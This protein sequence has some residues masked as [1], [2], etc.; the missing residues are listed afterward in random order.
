[1]QYGVLVMSETIWPSDGAIEA[2]PATYS[3]RGNVQV[4]YGAVG[5]KDVIKCL[6]RCLANQAYTSNRNP[7][8][9]FNLVCEVVS[10]LP[11]KARR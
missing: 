11:T 8:F 2:D 7:A 6:S 9:L 3:D 4:L 5:A 10:N 1:M